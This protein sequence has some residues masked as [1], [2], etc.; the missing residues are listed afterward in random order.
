MVSSFN[1]LV[2]TGMGGWI[3][4]R[5]S[6]DMMTRQLCARSFTQPIQEPHIWQWMY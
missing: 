6:A 3:H 5:A 1:C 4:P 2:L